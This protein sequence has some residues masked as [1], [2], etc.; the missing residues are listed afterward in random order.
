MEGFPELSRPVTLLKAQKKA[1]AD[2]LRPLK[3]NGYGF[4]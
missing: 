4:C 2:S 1:E 3:M